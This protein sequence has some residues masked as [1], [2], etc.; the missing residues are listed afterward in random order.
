LPKRQRRKKSTQHFLGQQQAMFHIAK[1]GEDERSV[2]HI[3][4]IL[5]FAFASEDSFTSLMRL[6]K[7]P[8]RMCCGNQ[9]CVRVDHI[10][11]H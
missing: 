11:I 4:R 10:S 5:A 1:P 3:N 2:V 6:P 9:L 7:Q 8:F